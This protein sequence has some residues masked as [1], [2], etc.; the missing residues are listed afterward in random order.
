VAESLNNLTQ[1]YQATNRLKEAEPLMKR[2]LEILLEFSRKTGHPHPHLQAVIRN[3][4][5]LLA[6]MGYK[7]EEIDGQLKKIFE[8]MEEA[9]GGN[10]G[11]EGE[12]GSRS[13]NHELRIKKG[14][15]AEWVRVRRGFFEL[16]G[17]LFS[18]PLRAWLKGDIARCAGLRD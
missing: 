13:K 9:P 11:A 16:E 3:Y 1:L 18:T 7:K 10:D 15:K 8:Q 17:R 5:G 12:G 4:A 6:E 14:K 2:A